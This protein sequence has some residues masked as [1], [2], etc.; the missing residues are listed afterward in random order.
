ME[1]LLRQKFSKTPLRRLLLATGEAE[2]IEGN[3]WGDTYWGVC[4]GVGQNHLGCLLMKI[5]GELNA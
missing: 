3:T 4:H 5:R 1:D 2:L